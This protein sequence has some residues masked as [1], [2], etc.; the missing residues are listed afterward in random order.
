MKL[1]KYVLLG[2]L[3]QLNAGLY[4]QTMILETLE[5]EQAYIQMAVSI[6]EQTIQCFDENL[7]STFEYS[8]RICNGH[9]RT[10]LR[11]DSV[12]GFDIQINIYTDEVAPNI[13]LDSWTVMFGKL[14]V[15]FPEGYLNDNLELKTKIMAVFEQEKERFKN[16]YYLNRITKQPSII[17]NNLVYAQ[18]ADSIFNDLIEMNLSPYGLNIGATSIYLDT[19]KDRFIMQ[20]RWMDKRARGY[21]KNY[22]MGHLSIMF[23]DYPKEANKTL[24]EKLEISLFTSGV[25]AIEIKEKIQEIINSQKQA[26]LEKTKSE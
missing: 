24:D 21:S 13:K 11:S 12:A 19:Y 9:L 15:A 22:E 1:I 17:Y 8:F 26:F 20:V 3:M 16:N 4:S 7:H 23:N 25:S 2:C 14:M 18:L 6:Q 10:T 5:K